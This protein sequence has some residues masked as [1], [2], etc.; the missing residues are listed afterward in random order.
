MLR[1]RVRWSSGDCSSSIA[2]RSLAQS[3]IKSGVVK[4]A[5]EFYLQVYVHGSTCQLPEEGVEPLKLHVLSE[6]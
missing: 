3:E 2:R 5:Q 1:L 6:K 4:F